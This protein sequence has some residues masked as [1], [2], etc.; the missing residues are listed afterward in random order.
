VSAGQ[1]GFHS[2]IEGRLS[3]GNSLRQVLDLGED[4]RYLAQQAANSHAPGEETLKNQRKLI[5][6]A[7]ERALQ[8]GATLWLAED[9][10]YRLTGSPMG[11]P[12]LDD[13]AGAPS[14]VMRTCLEKRCPCL[15]ESPGSAAPWTLDQGGGEALVCAAP[16]LLRDPQ[17]GHLLGALQAHRPDGPPFNAEEVQLLEGL[18][19]QAALALEA[20]LRLATEQWRLQQLSLVR[21]VSLQIADLH[22][23]DEI[24]SQITRLIQQ[25][26]D[27]YYVAIL[28]LEP[29]QEFLRFR[30]SAGPQGDED[31]LQAIPV[32]F[33]VGLGE[34]IIGYVAQTG[35]ELLANDIR[36]EPRYRALDALPETR[37]EATL[38]L[39]ARDRLL[40]VLDVQSNQLNDFDETDLLVLRALAGNIAMAAVDARL[41]S[42]LRRR[43]SQLSTV[44]EVSSAITS[45][46][47]QEKLLGEVVELIRKRFGYPYV[48]LYSV[49]PGRRKI[50]YEAGSG[51]RSQL[52]D[53]RNFILDLDAEQ[54]IIAWAARHGE[55][56]LANDVSQEPRYLPS[57]VE[58]DETRSELAVPLV[59]GEEVLGVLDIQ[60]EQVNAFGEDDR[61]LFE[62][63]ADHIA[64]AMRNAYLY[65]SEVWRRRV[66]DSVHQVAGLLSAEADL[67]R[68][69]AAILAELGRSLPLD[70]AAIWLLEGADLGDTPE[71]I[72]ALHLAAVIGAEALDLEIGL[73]PEDVL[74][75]NRTKVSPEI[76]QSAS[77]WLRQALQAQEPVVRSIES[78][79]EPLGAAMQF[80][81]DYSAIAAPL[82]VREQPR[83]VLVL[84][85]RTSG[86]YGSEARGMT[87]AFASYAAVAIEN[88]R[89]YEEAHEQ[90]WVSTVLLQVAN[91]TQ[92]LT[93]LPELLAT[94]AHITP[95]LAGVRACLLYILDEEG[96]FVPAVA[97]GLNGGQQAEFERWR[98]APGDVPALDHLVAERQPVILYSREDDQRLT[99]ILYPELLADHRRP[100][101]LSVLVPL[102]ARDQ[103]LG[104][105]LVDYSSPIMNNGKT[106]DSFFDE[107]LA[108]LQGIAHQ[109]AIAV[110]NIRLLKSQKEEAYV[111]VALLQVAQAVVSSNDLDE[112]LGSIVRITPILVGVKRALVFLWDEAQNT[113][114][115]SQSYGLPKAAE[116]PAYSL[117]EFPLLDAVLIEDTLLAHPLWGEISASD[118]VPEDWTYLAAPEGDKVDE[119]LENAPCLL[120]AFPLSVKGKVLGIFLVEEPEPIPGEGFSASNANRRLRGKR[121]EIITG[122]SQQAALAIQNDFLQYEMVEQERLE[123]EMQLAREIQSAF[124]PQSVPD[125]PGWDLKV[126]WRTA[127]EVGGDF[128]D[129][130]RLPGNRLGL[131]I[132]DVADKGMPAALFMTLVRTLVR[133]TV[134]EIDSPADVLERANDIIV[135]DAPG[136]MFVTIFYAVLDLDTGELEFANAGHNLPVVMRGQSC[137]L[138]LLRRGGMALGVEEGNQIQG[139]KTRLEVGDYLVLYTDGVTEAFSPQGEAFGEARLYQTIESAVHCQSHGDGEALA[140]QDVLEK[141]DQAVLEF[142]ADGLPS[143]DLTLLVLRRQE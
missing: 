70:L 96:D 125:L 12:A 89:L 32:A 64:I 7:A 57:P 100:T 49:H 118:Q 60:S 3:T 101:G 31:G 140:T 38:P 42:A 40:G 19:I 143:D 46:L 8:A 93:N 30:A 115:L 43:A 122:I 61:F 97:S 28:T 22:D 87:A 131:V 98:F 39:R 6:A 113:F 92:S 20:S 123:R 132:A 114:R 56:V 59:F 86:R 54:G 25:T 112:A 18:A 99:S 120:I 103:V 1:P 141:I 136:G 129:Y 29:D 85:H 78:A 34:G 83:G 138:E 55:T 4:L 81:A 75:F 79:Y 67:D 26:F 84:A 94:V 5:L 53:E 128:Y 27:Y 116:V 139:W 69:L 13:L 68:V 142:I 37:S 102:A 130:F 77:G 50:F 45:I 44:Y 33:Q 58:P 126:R 52:L 104:V 121:L 133:A 14:D 41:Y 90:A 80:P 48:H 63:L 91:A 10:V 21:E 108:I 134:K 105:M 36:Q 124:L 106:V 2:P 65:R 17:A 110:D 95:M 107:R 109:T 74:D 137:Q 35:D 23:L 47:D 71:D 119:Y 51:P 127:R 82:R 135:P 73:T 9:V 24:A 66:A 11:T 15:A 111:S 117:G 72:P 62:A 88:A 16:L 76:S